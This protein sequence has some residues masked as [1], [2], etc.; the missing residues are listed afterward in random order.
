MRTSRSYAN[1]IEN[2]AESARTSA[3][4]ARSFVPKPGASRTLPVAE[5]DAILNKFGVPTFEAVA[6]TGEGVFPTLKTLA[7]MVLE[8]IEKIDGRARAS[9]RPRA[10]TRRGHACAPPA[11]G[12]AAAPALSAAA[13]AAAR[14]AGPSGAPRQR[15]PAVSAMNAASEGRGSCCQAGAPAAAAPSATASSSSSRLTV[16]A[17]A[18]AAGVAYIICSNTRLGPGSKPSYTTRC[19]R[20][21]GCGTIA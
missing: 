9:P 6:Y 17:L 4:T 2:L 18:A 7:A 15:R 16:A 3:S 8:S 11:A 21:S 1:L 10:P 12:C 13:S 19:R 14:P 5:I 20:T